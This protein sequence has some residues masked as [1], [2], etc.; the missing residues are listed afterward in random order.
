M[1]K[2]SIIQV[3][4]CWMLRYYEPV[5]EN[6]KVVKRQ[7][8][9]KIGD[10]HSTK[11][12]REAQAALILAPINA[13]AARPESRQDL[14]TFLEHVYLPHVKESKRPSTYAAYLAVWRLVKDHANGLELRAARTSDIDR[15]LVAATSDK[16]RAHTTHRNLKNF[17]SAAFRHAKRNDLVESNPV[18]DAA[19]P[20]GKPA[21][22]TPAYTLEEIQAML[23]VL[24][25]PAKT[26]VTV[27]ALTGLRVSE[28]KGL[29]WEDFKG[30][31]LNVERSVWQGHIS[32]TKTL[33]SKAAVP[34]L[35]LVS[36]A[37]AAHK[38]RTPDSGY[39]FA[40]STGQPLRIENV[41]RRDMKEI[42]EKNN[43]QW[44]GWHGFRRGVGTNLHALGADD[45]TIQ[46]I[47]RHSDVSTTMTFYVKPVA[48]ESH[49]A[50]KKLETAFK[51]SGRR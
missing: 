39:I 38:K 15:L 22:D 5:L 25:E 31:E 33:S 51:K 50:M 47:L 21:G 8:T 48:K 43:I 32:E 12:E 37:L 1:Q 40:G 18:R 4:N 35:P 2:G 9:K 24:S 26:F 6:G 13:K 30:N 10:Q 34:V 3:G 14:G 41:Y 45:K 11:D 36:R 29:R 7:K 23:H 49:A 19:I 16:K 46:A 44:R 20:R 28:I 42:F 27:A 17:L